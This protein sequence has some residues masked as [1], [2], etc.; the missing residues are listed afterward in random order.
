MAGETDFIVYGFAE[1][2]GPVGYA[3]LPSLQNHRRCLLERVLLTSNNAKANDFVAT[4]VE[5]EETARLD[6]DWLFQF[7]IGCCSYPAA[8]PVAARDV[9]ELFAVNSPNALP[10]NCLS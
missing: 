8:A 3:L 10:R 7:P 5:T 6:S 9:V 1:S 4:V 2:S